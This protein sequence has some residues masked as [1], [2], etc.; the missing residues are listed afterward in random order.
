MLIEIKD[1]CLIEYQLTFENLQKR[2]NDIT[3][4]V[5]TIPKEMGE[6]FGRHMMG[7]VDSVHKP[8]QK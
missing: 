7:L 2:M 5:T 8:Q 6:K 3:M 1:N 4:V